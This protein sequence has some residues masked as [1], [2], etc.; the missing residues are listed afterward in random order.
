MRETGDFAEKI[1]G[2]A[3]MAVLAVCGNLLEI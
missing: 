1:D 3:S 2:G